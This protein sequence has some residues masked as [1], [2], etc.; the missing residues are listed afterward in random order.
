M[1]LIKYDGYEYHFKDTGFV[2]ELNFDQFY[3]EEDI[4]RQK[5]IE[6]YGYSFIR[7]N[8]FLLKDDP[9]S[10]INKHLENHCKKKLQ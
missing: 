2:N 6:S 10:Y 4:E 3:V 5:T 7:L 1:S 8:K 9:I